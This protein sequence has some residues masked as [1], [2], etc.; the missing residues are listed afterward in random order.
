MREAPP[1][2]GSSLT[3]GAMDIHASQLVAAFDPSSCRLLGVYSKRLCHH[4]NELLLPLIVEDTGV[5]RA[6]DQSLARRLGDDDWVSSSGLAASIAVTCR[7]VDW[8]L[9][10]A[11][12][13]PAQFLGCVETAVRVIM[14]L[15]VV[16]QTASEAEYA[17]AVETWMKHTAHQR[18][19]IGLVAINAARRL[20]SKAGDLINDAARKLAETADSG[21]RIWAT[22][23]LAPL[24][25]AL[26]PE[27]V[28]PGGQ[29]LIPCLASIKIEID[30]KDAMTALED[31]LANA[32]GGAEKVF[33]PLCGTVDRVWAERCLAGFRTQ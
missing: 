2:H 4:R 26:A 3:Q 13:H 33:A 30:Y 21:S 12:D 23:V 10:Q 6:A 1:I 9:L 17:D 15:S 11:V 27:C 25:G 5:A 32:D 8:M 20:D 18:V 22:F 7:I 29:A 14:R 16:I 19:A 24:L 31:G 28:K